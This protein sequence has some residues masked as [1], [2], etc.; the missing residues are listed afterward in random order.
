VQY[1]SHADHLNTPRLIADEQQRTVWRWDHTDPFGG[2]PPDENP[3]G[4]GTFEFPLRFP[5]QYAD[6]ETNLHY[7]YNRNYDPTLGRYEES[8]LIGLDDGVNTYAYVR[9]NPLALTDLL[10]LQSF[11][12]G[13]RPLDGCGPNGQIRENF[14]PDLI[15][16]KCCDGHDA[17]YDDCVRKPSKASCDQNFCGC[18]RKA[19]RTGRRGGPMFPGCLWLADRACDAVAGSIAQQQF[20]DARKN[21]KDCK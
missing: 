6:K 2:N 21:C 16:R 3:S 19:C 15:F 18:V 10:G 14:V 12:G 7:N 5:G 9:G 8:D 4:L 20:D 11:R 13:V 17:C 1:I